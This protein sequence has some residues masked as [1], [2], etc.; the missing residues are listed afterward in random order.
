MRLD[1]SAD[2]WGVAMLGAAGVAVLGLVIVLLALAMSTSKRAGAWILSLGCAAFLVTAAFGT[3]ARVREADA[4]IRK[5]PPPSEPVKIIAPDVPPDVDDPTGDAPPAEG[6]AVPEGATPTDVVPGGTDGEPI[7]AEP[8]P[9]SD[10]STGEPAAPEPPASEAATTEGAEPAQ[11]DADP[12]GEP[13]GP[14]P[15]GDTA[16]PEAPPTA[17]APSAGVVALEAAPALPSEAAA[18]REA[19]LERLRAA[20]TVALDD[21][22]CRDARTI[23]Q[24][25]VGIAA[26]PREV[27]TDRVAVIVRRLERCRRKIAGTRAWALHRDRTAARKAFADT[28]RDR[29]AP[30]HAGVWVA[31]SGKDEIKLRVGAKSLAT[32]AVDTL[33]AAGLKAELEGLGFEGAFFSD[34]KKGQTVKLEPKSDDVLLAAELEPLGLHAPFPEP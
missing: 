19:V 25:W 23:A 21:E 4:A 33:L 14:A 28:L 31:T 29:L 3:L 30:D 2:P 17:P 1:L 13:P 8:V 27:L 26:I 7:A 9:T 12:E 20:K 24:T 22:S 16:K 34:G 10:A 32:A 15:P 18:Q 5:Q 11:E 6:K